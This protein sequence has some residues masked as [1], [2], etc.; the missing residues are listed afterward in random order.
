MSVLVWL[1]YDII[2]KYFF[3]G[4]LNKYFISPLPFVKS[5]G[6]KSNSFKNRIWSKEAMGSKK[7]S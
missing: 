3:L 5:T 6:Q 7:N 1:L 2:D 4:G